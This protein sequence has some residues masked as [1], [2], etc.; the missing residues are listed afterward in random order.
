MASMTLDVVP[1]GDPA[2]VA[3]DGGDVVTGVESLGQELGTAAPGGA[4][5]EKSHD[6]SVRVPTR[7]AVRAR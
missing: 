2:R 3:G 1:H 5:D 4:E 6:R 7:A